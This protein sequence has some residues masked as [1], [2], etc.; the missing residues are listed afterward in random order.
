MIRKFLSRIIN[1]I[2]L[3][4]PYSSFDRPIFIIAP[5]RSG[6]T[7]LFNCLSQFH[8]LYK[9]DLEADYIWWRHFPYESMEAPSDYV[10]VESISLKN[11]RSILRHIYK[12]AI[13]NFLRENPNQLRFPYLFGLK[14]IRYLDKTIANCFHLPFLNRAFPNAQY[15]FLVR[16]PRANISSMIEGWS[17]LTRF[18]KPQLSP[19]FPDLANTGIGHWTYP[20]PPGWQKV[21]SKPIEEVCAWSWKQHINYAIDFFQQNSKKVVNVKYEDLV[22]DTL[23]LIV[24]LA[25]KL[26]LKLS[27]KVYEFIK[28]SPL[29]HTTI[30]KPFK[31]K[32][33]TINYEQ[34]LSILPFVEDTASQIGYDLSLKPS[35]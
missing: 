30:S 16:D 9:L 13:S 24:N 26:D 28:N 1:R 27:D 21:V 29:S 32:W 8:E 25:V 18:G 15:I 22:S 34:V 19:L 35:T 12:E 4:A 17:H 23:N 7:F 6:S 14:R 2:D 31:N 11:T 33:E 10:G 3:A 5:P 20:A